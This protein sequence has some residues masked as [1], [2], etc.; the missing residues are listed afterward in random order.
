[1]VTLLP[2][3]PTGFLGCYMIILPSLD[4]SALFR[5]LPPIL[6][7]QVAQHQESACQ[8]GFDPWIGK[9]LWRR[10]W[11]PAPILLPGK[12]HGRRSLAGY[13]PRVLKESAMTE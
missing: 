10:K 11:Q 8:R 12:S 2:F 4:T 7:S 3:S 13:T 5:N 6:A 1:M 9:I